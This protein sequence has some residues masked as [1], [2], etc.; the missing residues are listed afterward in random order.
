MKNPIQQ[1]YDLETNGKIHW[2]WDAGFIV[3]FNRLPDGTYEKDYYV[4]TWQ[5]VE[6]I[7]RKK[8]EEKS[9]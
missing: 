7:F 3:Y 9:K 1:Y 8:L 4:D 6:Q 5:E 2:Q